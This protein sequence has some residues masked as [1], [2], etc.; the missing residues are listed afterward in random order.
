MAANINDKLK[1]IITGSIQYNS[2]HLA[3][4]LLITRLKSKYS[5]TPSE[6]ILTECIAEANAFFE[7]YQ[8]VLTEEMEKILGL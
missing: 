4:G 5:K 1:K 2:P 6:E 3:M 8:R 7:K